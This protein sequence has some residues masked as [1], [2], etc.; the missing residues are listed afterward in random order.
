MKK[1]EK[2]MIAEIQLML[3]F[4]TSDPVDENGESEI[5]HLHDD[6]TEIHTLL[7]NMTGFNELEQ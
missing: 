5:P 1:T 3:A 7:S 2:Q 6:L 4:I